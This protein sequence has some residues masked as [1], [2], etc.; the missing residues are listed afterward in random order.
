MLDLK[1]AA[2]SYLAEREKGFS[3]NRKLTVGASEIGAC[4]RRTWY[5]KRLG[6]EHYNP[7]YKPANG[8]AARGDLLEDQFTVPVLKHALAKQ[9]GTG[10][11][12][13]WA[14]DGQQH[15]IQALEWRLSATPDGLVI[16]A[17]RNALAGYGV[18]DILANCFVV[19]CKSFD[20]RIIELPKAQ[21][22]D[23]LNVQL[24][25]IR[26]E[27]TYAPAFGIVAYVNASFPD[28]IRVFPKFFNQ[29]EFDNQIRRAM[30]ILGANDAQQ[31]QPEGKIAG[32]KEC[33]YCPFA[34]IC[35]G[36][37]PSVPGGTK[38]FDA[39]PGGKR[40]ALRRAI[41]KV[42]N[43]RRQLKDLESIEAEGEAKVKDALIDAGTKR[44]SGALKD[45]TKFR[46][47][48]EPTA[49]RMSWDNEMLMEA[50]NQL[51]LNP[52]DFR[53]EGKVGERLTIKLEPV[54]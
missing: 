35:L 53:K 32:E 3:H 48:W 31:L 1:A 4:A 28:D 17:P 36:Y 5:E 25:L 42:A 43:A 20:P 41:G 18:E 2:V 7:D 34:H 49:P 16:N 14:G 11:N 44:A 37:A 40:E 38:Q 46:V 13:I 12:L 27:G 24:G 15:T 50:L 33:A 21:H 30:A 10:P 22:M 39:L 26:K 6:S 52:D 47:T 9:I 8:A 29:V 54:T 51:G 23:Q 19:E 45:G